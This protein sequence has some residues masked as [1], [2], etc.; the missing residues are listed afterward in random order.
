MAKISILDIAQAVVSKH[1]LS[2]QEAEKFVT[3]FFDVINEGL[4][5]DKIVKVKGFGTFKVIDV[6][7]RE[8]VNVNT[9]E[10]VVIESHGKL[11]FT[12]DPIMRDLVNKPFAQFETVVLNE[13]VDLD[14]IN[15]VQTPEK[16]TETVPE[17]ADFT[18]NDG[19]GDMG[20]E[21]E[22]ENEAVI[23]SEEQGVTENVEP[24]V[25]VQ[26]DT[27]EAG[28]GDKETSE[29]AVVAVDKAVNEVG[30]ENGTDDELTGSE[31]FSGSADNENHNVRAVVT[32]V[33]DG[34]ENAESSEEQELV[35]PQD[36][37][38]EVDVAVEDGFF[39]RHRTA[40]FTLI[41]LLIAAAAFTGGYYYGR[42]S[43][44]PVVK[45]RTVK[46]AVKPDSTE[47]T[48]DT[49]QREDT[50]SR[51]NVVKPAADTVK[52]VESKKTVAPEENKSMHENVS[53]QELKNAHSMVNTGA[54]RIVGTSETVTVKHGETLKKIS[55]FYLG[56][57]MECY[58]QVHNGIAEVTEG[59]KLKI[60]KLE[61]K[62]RK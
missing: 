10:R 54:Y 36:N 31:D 37:E 47:V 13:G 12:P 50:V 23:V 61:L 32:D 9:G 45:Y 21:P 56:E 22:T 38:D 11:T 40:F 60:P 28:V 48:A 30:N 29:E 58:V 33:S 4:N 20:R 49:T 18:E 59:M 53:S 55:R 35:Q 7:E 34:K 62:R 24:E 15:S 3:A 8:S 27:V 52:T 44:S 19:S 46:V 41:C 57:G 26:E 14:E 17:D 25:T 5:S 6:R 2:Q 39:S 16:E 1:G 42:G 51:V 43:V